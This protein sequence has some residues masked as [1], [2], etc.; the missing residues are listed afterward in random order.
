M[1]TRSRLSLTG[2][3]EGREK[4]SLLRCLATIGLAGTGRT[5]NLRPDDGPA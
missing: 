1:K 4:D 2:P 3:E 5:E